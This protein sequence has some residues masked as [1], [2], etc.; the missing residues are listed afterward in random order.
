MTTPV[1]SS[2]SVATR[3]IQT[4]GEATKKN[5]VPG[6]TD[7]SLITPEDVNTRANQID[8]NIQQT[9]Q[10]AEQAKTATR[11]TALNVL[12]AQRKQ[13]LVDQFIA[14]STDSE[15]S[16]SSGPSLTDIIKASQNSQKAD[17]LDVVAKVVQQRDD[18]EERFNE[19]SRP[20]PEPS[21]SVDA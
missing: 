8:Q 1:S 3:I 17:A 7:P 19:I 4:V 5:V 2:T 11:T 13:D 14:Q 21:F 15:S 6:Q 18:L 16:T 20:K 9:Q 12:D 10:A